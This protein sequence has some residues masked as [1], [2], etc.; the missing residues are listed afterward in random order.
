MADYTGTVQAVELVRGPDDAY[1]AEAAGGT[2]YSAAIS[3]WNDTANTIAGGSDTL[4]VNAATAT[5]A[6]RS[7]VATK[8]SS[9]SSRLVHGAN[10]A[11]VATEIGAVAGAM[12][13]R[14][15]RMAIGDA[16]TVTAAEMGR[17]A[18][19]MATG[20]VVAVT[21]MM[22]TTAAKVVA[23]E[24]LVSLRRRRC[25][26]VQSRSGFDPDASIARRYWL[27][28]PPSSSQL[29]SLRSKVWPQFAA[30]SQRKTHVWQPRAGPSCPKTR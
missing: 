24:G 3:I 18:G 11:N 21:A 27:T 14:A 23:A 2:V 8:S 17:P 12:T 7:S 13:V 20:V 6:S 10:A 28:F 26:S 16:T 25:R 9:R 5:T 19:A 30:D 29:P 15:A 22:A 4:A 1:G